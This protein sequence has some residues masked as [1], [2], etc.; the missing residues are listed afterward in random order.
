MARWVGYK[1]FG[2]NFLANLSIRKK[3]AGVILVTTILSLGSAFAL[4]YLTTIRLFEDHLLKTSLLIAKAAGD[5]SAVGLFFDDR[6]EAQ[7][8][9]DKLREFPNVVEA[10]LFNR[11]R[12]RFVTVGAPENLSQISEVPD[13]SI[14][15]RDGFV[16]VFAPVVWEGKRHG[17]IY[18]RCTTEE[19]E[20]QKSTYLVYMLSLM[21]GFVLVAV[22]FAY[23][24]QGF[25]TKPILHLVSLAERISTY[26]DYSIRVEKP[27]DDEIGALYDGFNAMLTQIEARQLELERSN[28]DLDQFA[29]VAS[30]DLK[31]PLRAI[32]TLS[33]WL[34]EDLGDNLSADAQNQLSLLRSRV[35]RMDS[36]IEGVLR[37]SRVRRM[38]TEGEWVDV[39]ELVREQ[40][41]LIGPPSTFTFEV[42]DDLPVLLTRRLRLGQVFGNLITNAIKYHD[43][44]HGKIVI[45]VEDLGDGLFRFSVSDD[46]PGIPS[47]HHERVF[48]MFQTL[49][50]RDAIESTGLGL[51]LVKKLV[52][53]EGGTVFLEQKTGRG[54]TFRFTWKALGNQEPGALARDSSGPEGPKSQPA[55]DVR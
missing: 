17:T 33:G 52:E 16:H 11:D 42:A 40:I 8:A 53:E 15:M 12:E 30:H 14:E 23:V 35:Q 50:S 43:R 44:D 5:Y 29:Y 22:I 55:P 34:E 13:E 46:G 10:Q 41:E 4:V 20:R 6:E 47:Q 54:A 37:Y 18:V 51:S 1:G 24:L 28:R 31:A 38:E 36:L 25:I 21:I 26:A 2:L 3:I 9:L 49:Q 45:S 7:G 19:L 48:V 27:G 32:A 39:K